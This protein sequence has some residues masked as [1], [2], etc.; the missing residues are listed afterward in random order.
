MQDGVRVGRI[1]F[2]FPDGGQLQGTV[3]EDGQ[4]GG[5]DFCYTYPDGMSRLRG[6][7]LAA[8]DQEVEQQIQ[9]ETTMGDAVYETDLGV[10]EQRAPV[11]SK[12]CARA[13][14][15]HQASCSR[16]SYDPGTT[17]QPSSSPLLRDPYEAWRTGVRPSSVRFEGD[18]DSFV[19]QYRHHPF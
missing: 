7:W 14:L 12:G 15:Q 1:A 3:D 9:S 11:S 5:D 16:F 6:R 13:D 2:L 10:S 18:F 4:V 8:S 19:T 17:R